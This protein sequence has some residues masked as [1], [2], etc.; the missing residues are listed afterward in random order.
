MPRWSGKELDDKRAQALAM[1]RQAV[2]DMSDHDDWTT[3]TEIAWQKMSEV[4][5][6]A[7]VAILVRERFGKRPDYAD[8][9]LAKLEK[10]DR[11]RKT[12]KAMNFLFKCIDID[13]KVF[14]QTVVDLVEGNSR[15]P[16]SAA[17][18]DKRVDPQDSAGKR[19]DDAG[20]GQ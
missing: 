6:S 3:L 9:H 14:L 4:V 20:A 5:D 10:Y 17:A 7:R 1:F 16:D 15:G 13:W 8:E 2:T 12:L 19:D 11:Y 18:G